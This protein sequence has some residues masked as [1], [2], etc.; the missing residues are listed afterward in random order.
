MN[1]FQRVFTVWR[2]NMDVYRVTWKVNFIPPLLEPM[3]YLLAFGAGLGGFVKTIP[4]RGGEVGYTS[5]I[6]P[7]MVGISVMFSS[8]FECTYG[9]YIRMYYQ[10]T[11]D[12]I[13]ATPLNLED[14]ILGEIIWGATK[15]FI[16]VAIMC[17]V[18][19]AFGYMSFPDLLVLPFVAFLAGLFFASLGMCYTSIC[20][21]IDAFN[22]PIF[23]FIT[24]MSLFGGTYFPVDHLPA[25]AKP[26]AQFMP[27]Y[28]LTWVTRSIAFGHWDAGVWIRLAG[29]ALT[30]VPL[31]W[32][33]VR[34]MKRRLIL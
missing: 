5:F 13:I 12:A 1:A 6:A 15:S 17:G 8:F 31:M 7:G 21:S 19:R 3:F 23:L 2:R 29:F 32:C 33:A 27:L 9:S 10:K 25:W 18:I 30:V 16:S 34:L 22:Y 20:P 24:P 26:V 4:Y 14:V 28:H 11:F